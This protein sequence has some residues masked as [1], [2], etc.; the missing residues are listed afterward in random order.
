MREARRST[1]SSR[2]PEV[3]RAAQLAV[4]CLPSR[5]DA[6]VGDLVRAEPFEALELDVGELFEPQLS[7]WR[8]P[9]RS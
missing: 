5:M 7:G 8:A 4:E 2:C 1:T 9:S 3:R 6:G